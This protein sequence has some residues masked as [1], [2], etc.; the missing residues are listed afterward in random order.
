M[1]IQYIYLKQF[2]YRCGI[3]VANKTWDERH[4]QGSDFPK[5]PASFLKE[6][7]HR[8][9]RGKAL[10]LAMGI[11]RNSIFLAM[12][13]YEVDSIDF[14]EVAIEKVRSFAQKK[15]LLIHAMKADLTH[16]QISENTYDV[17]LNF[18]FLERL[19]I[20]H[21]KKGLKQGGMILFETYTTEQPH[22]GRPHNPAYLLKP[23]ELLHSFMDLHIIYYHERVDT[24]KEET[25]AIASLLAQK[26]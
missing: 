26:R 11:G 18:Y 21:I 10:D 17:I 23:N 6:H 24:Q 4:E 5:E 12:N 14:S 16:Y 9:P 25:K 3:R 13:G 15:S 2:N 19:L 7:I 8:L 1:L 20:P 22:Y